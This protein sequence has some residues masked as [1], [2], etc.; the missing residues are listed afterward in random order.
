MTP[1]IAAALLLATHAATAETGCDVVHV[2]GYVRTEFSPWTADGTSI[3]AD[4]P[5]AA[6]SYD[7]PINA[8]VSIPALDRTVV[9]HDRGRLGNGYP[10]TWID[11][12]TWSRR[13]ALDL[14]GDYYACISVPWGDS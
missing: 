13:E 8:V 1:F 10:K 4:L 9:V 11:I 5:I 14:T 12:A 6:A 7:V 3:Y 2:T